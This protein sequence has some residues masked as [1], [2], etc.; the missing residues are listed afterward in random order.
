MAQ[1]RIEQTKV[2][3]PANSKYGGSSKYLNLNNYGGSSRNNERAPSRGSINSSKS[4]STS[5]RPNMIKNFVSM[6]R[7]NLQNNVSPNKNY[8]SKPNFV[9]HNNNQSGMGLPKGILK[10][11]NYPA[12]TNNL[13]LNQRRGSSN[14]NKSPYVNASSRGDQQAKHNQN[15][16]NN[17]N[18]RSAKN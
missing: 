17:A 4:T 2:Y 18:Y 15:A 13:Y 11:N 16:I 5:A 7:P 10:K 9:L 8:L 12:N 1:R 14:I 6:S 3:N